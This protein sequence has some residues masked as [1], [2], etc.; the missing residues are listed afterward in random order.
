MEIDTIR[1]LQGV[2]I[3]DIAIVVNASLKH[4]ASHNQATAHVNRVGHFVAL[5]HSELIAI[6]IMLGGEVRIVVDTH[7]EV[8]EAQVV[9]SVAH[10]SI[11]SQGITRSNTC[12]EV[13]WTVQIPVACCSGLEVVV[14]ELNLPCLGVYVIDNLGLDNG[15]ITN[16]G[17]CNHLLCGS[18]LVRIVLCHLNVLI[19]LRREGCYSHEHSNSD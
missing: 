14:L 3:N 19:L 17:W 1:G 7:T 15:G 6:A 18:H 11:R 10:H 5:S 9:R 2:A 8:A 4:L 13:L 16:L 12:K